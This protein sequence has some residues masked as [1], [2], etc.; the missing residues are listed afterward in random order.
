MDGLKRGGILSQL[1]NIKKL[2]EL[3]E[4]GG[5]TWLGQLMST[6]QLIAWLVQFDC[7]FEEKGVVLKV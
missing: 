6:P 2:N 1:L 7:W 3:K 4:K 5:G